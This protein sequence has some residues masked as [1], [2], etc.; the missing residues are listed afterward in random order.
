[1]TDLPEE[2]RYVVET[3]SGSVKTPILKHRLKDAHTAPSPRG[4]LRQRV[5]DNI[6]PDQ[7]KM[8]KFSALFAALKVPALRE[9]AEPL[10][11]DEWVQIDELIAQFEPMARIEDREAY[12]TLVAELTVAKYGDHSHTVEVCNVLDAYNIDPRI[13][14]LTTGRVSMGLDMVGELINHFD[15]HQLASGIPEPQPLIEVLAG[16][17]EI[18]VVDETETVPAVPPTPEPEQEP[19]VAAL[20][21]DAPSVPATNDDIQTQLE[22]HMTQ[23]L[24]SMFEIIRILTTK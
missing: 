22:D 5:I 19:S 24:S 14:L 10:T 15:M 23:V 6:A 1:M 4:N 16:F 17:G 9:E 7:A 12:K 11:Y 8:D 20:P 21:S 3:N 18:E 2:D 13:P